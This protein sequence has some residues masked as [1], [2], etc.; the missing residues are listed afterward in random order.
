MGEATLKAG[1][2]EL[3]VRVVGMIEDLTGRPVRIF[4]FIAEEF[5]TLVLFP[6]DMAD[7]HL[8]FRGNAAALIEAAKLLRAVGDDAMLKNLP[9]AVH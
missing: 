9:G 3:T 4:Q 6:T 8:S 2:L 5:E 1:G 7:I